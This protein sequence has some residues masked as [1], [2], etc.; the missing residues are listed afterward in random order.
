MS[1]V[2]DL[3]R[4]ELERA[5]RERAETKQAGTARGARD[6]APKGRKPRQAKELRRRRG[7]DRP[8]P[9]ADR[10]PPKSAPRNE[11]KAKAGQREPISSE[12][13]LRRLCLAG[14]LGAL[15]TALARLQ[16]DNESGLTRR[17]W[18]YLLSA[19]SRRGDAQ[20]CS[21]V[22]D[23]MLN[24]PHTGGVAGMEP[25]LAQGVLC[26][27]SSLP[28][29]ERMD[30]VLERVARFG[31]R[32]GAATYSEL[33]SDCLASG[34]VD[35]A[36]RVVKAATH[37][38]AAN[39]VVCG[40]ELR[41]LAQRCAT[42]DMDAASTAAIGRR[43]VSA[44]QRARRD[45]RRAARN[46]ALRE[47]VRDV[48]YAV[49]ASRATADAP[50]ATELDDVEEELRT[51]AQAVDVHVP[52]LDG[53]ADNFLGGAAQLSRLR[54]ALSE[55]ISSHGRGGSGGGS[56]GGGGGRKGRGGG[57]AA[58]R[59]LGKEAREAC[60]GS[61]PL[62]ALARLANAEV[63]DK[64]VDRACALE[65]ELEGRG[66]RLSLQQST[67]LAVLC[68]EHGREQEALERFDAVLARFPRAAHAPSLPWAQLLGGAVRGGHHALA[69][70]IADA[71]RSRGAAPT[72][73]FLNA[74]AWSRAQCGDLRG[75]EALVD[76]LVGRGLTPD[77]GT[78]AAVACAHA[79]TGRFGD[80]LTACAA[81]ARA[82]GIQLG[83]GTFVDFARRLQWA[84]EAPAR[85][86]DAAED[87]GASPHGMGAALRDWSA[88]DTPAPDVARVCED[89]V[90]LLAAHGVRP[91]VRFA[92]TLGGALAR[93]GATPPP[94]LRDAMGLG[95]HSEQGA[96]VS[97]PRAGAAQV[98]R[99]VPSP[100]VPLQGLWAWPWRRLARR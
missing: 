100:R 92:R 49:H 53:A 3:L 48:L 97:R 89:L 73:P 35:T 9:S 14:D 64:R 86:A 77:S 41:V 52:S 39:A 38:K 43:A 40:L 69:E 88:T 7:S 81:L 2:V 50:A 11:P 55:E 26:S 66:G 19:A 24:T 29:D 46:S 85:G 84:A 33:L 56:G 83:I 37:A 71:A 79:A 8:P 1:E 70:R 67:A 42:G 18:S 23:T 30:A 5:A 32:P 6:G 96:P 21:E 36:E 98:P 61:L 31:V 27:C 87:C 62:W 63:L 80:G 51:A 57:M 34:A 22:V 93:A 74:L 4:R 59:R 25:L 94:A 60:G 28:P 65:T 54:V 78:A 82:H 20:R 99:R 16:A 58:V 76:D 44:L 12:E 45:R 17:H 13:E 72:V 47:G 90:G 10:A 75:V 15:E 95:A 68:A 91:D